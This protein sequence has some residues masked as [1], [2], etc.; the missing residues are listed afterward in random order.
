M[1]KQMTA[2]QYRCNWGHPVPNHYRECSAKESLRGL[3]A[4]L[5]YRPTRR[6]NEAYDTCPIAEAFIRLGPTPVQFVVVYGHPL[7]R[8]MAAE[9]NRKLMEMVES[10][11]TQSPVP[12]IIAGDFNQPPQDILAC[13]NLLAQDYRDPHEFHLARTG[14]AHYPKPAGAV[15]P[16]T[17]SSSTRTC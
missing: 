6:L 15:R 10:R 8:A 16:M 9:E 14:V 17:L 5:L 13:Q 1:S 3:A 11:D 2:Q 4:A 7:E 12:A